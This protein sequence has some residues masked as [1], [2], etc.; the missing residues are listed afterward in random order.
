[1]KKTVFVVYF[2]FFTVVFQACINKSDSKTLPLIL[3][4]VKPYTPADIG[5]TGPDPSENAAQAAL[6]VISERER[7]AI[8]EMLEYMAQNEM[9]TDTYWHTSSR[10]AKTVLFV[11]PFS[12]S[13]LENEI[14]SRFD[15]GSFPEGGPPAS[16][17]TVL[18]RESK[19][20]DDFFNRVLND[21]PKISDE[22][23]IQ[24]RLKLT[25]SLV[26][27]RLQ[28][29]YPDQTNGVPDEILIMVKE[30]TV[31]FRNKINDELIR[32]GVTSI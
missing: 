23:L 28:R 10:A 8:G 14:D 6:P 11:E 20:A 2:L 18:A 7:K 4:E 27:I 31:V 3:G 21:F 30:K 5:L 9:M 16:L 17:E 15:G 1:M 13:A 19:N 25:L 24:L 22:Q 32:R 26:M 29:D 12:D